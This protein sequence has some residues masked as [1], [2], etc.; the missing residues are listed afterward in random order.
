MQ[1]NQIKFGKEYAVLYEGK[2]HALRVETM[3]NERTSPTV[4][5]NYVRGVITTLPRSETTGLN[6]G[7]TF[8]VA[9]VKEEIEAY[10]ELVEEKARQRAEAE[11]K[12][13]AATAKK[14]LAATLLAEAIGVPAILESKA[15][16]YR[17][18]ADGPNVRATYG[19]IDINS[20]AFDALI[21]FLKNVKGDSNVVAMVD[22][23][24]GLE[25]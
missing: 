11:A 3:I 9:D 10:R 16:N 20:K 14:E 22:R 15:A 2:L 13:A 18:L 12:Q 25:A 19:S 21:T 4:S 17:E 5:T 23:K 7:A 24:L 8:K 1:A 6:K